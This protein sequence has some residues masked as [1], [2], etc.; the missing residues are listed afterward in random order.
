MKRAGDI[1][2]WQCLPSGHKVLIIRFTTET[3]KEKRKDGK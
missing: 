1:A 3:M 2:Q